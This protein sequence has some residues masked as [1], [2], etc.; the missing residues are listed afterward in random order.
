VLFRSIRQKR[1]TDLP[2]YLHTDA[3]QASNYLDLHASRLG[4]DLMTV[5]GGKIYG[6]KQSGFL[7]LK[8][9]ITL[10]PQILGGGQ[11]RGLRSGT[12][13]VPAIIGLSTAFDKSQTI[14]SDESMRLG[15]LQSYFIAQLELH[16]PRAIVNGSVKHR[17][18]NN[19]HIT[20]PDSDNERLLF[21]LDEAGIMAAA[22]SACSAS[23]Q[24]PS[25][26][27]KAIGLS[28]KDA[29][30]SLRFSMGRQTKKSEVDQIIHTL[31]RVTS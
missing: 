24:T 13:N 31:K 22:G 3:C 10:S 1:T 5:N 27:L 26:V 29:R 21:A 15:D 12:E 30:S 23:S 6:P 28:D 14:K 25:H 18:P 2:I 19:V 20:I 4:V 8:S 9:G 11:E 16:I 17:L 7:F